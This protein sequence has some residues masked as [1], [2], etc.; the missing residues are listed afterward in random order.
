VT[1]YLDRFPAYGM[2]TFSFSYC[3]QSR[4]DTARS[5]QHLNEAKTDLEPIL[6]R[7][8]KTK[9][10][11]TSTAGKVSQQTSHIWPDSRYSIRVWQ[12]DSEM[13]LLVQKT[14][15]FV[16]L[17]FPASKIPFCTGVD[18]P[19]ALG[20]SPTGTAFLLLSCSNYI[21]MNEYVVK[22]TSCL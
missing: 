3:P 7:K 17:I 20:T 22:M 6:E 2:R 13:L 9:H 8:R 15:A 14:N 10:I 5:C 19:H 1:E 16:Q 12:A 18:T 21:F 11:N 4:R